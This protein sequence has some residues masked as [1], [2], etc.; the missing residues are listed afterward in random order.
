MKGFECKIVNHIK[1]ISLINSRIISQ[2]KWESWSIYNILKQHWRFNFQK[3]PHLITREYK[4]YWTMDTLL[5]YTISMEFILSANFP[6]RYWLLMRIEIRQLV[7]FTWFKYMRAHYM[8]YNL[9]IFQYRTK[10][11]M[12][13][14]LCR[15]KYLM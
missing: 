15:L 11:L 13:L 7:I 10:E 3:V 1:R 4:M 12:V 8:K 14:L 5:Q 2:F 9:M 6:N